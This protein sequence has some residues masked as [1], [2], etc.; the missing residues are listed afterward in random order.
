ML[1]IY[2]RLHVIVMLRTENNS[3]CGSASGDLGQS[4]LLCVCFRF[5]LRAHDI[6]V[7]PF[8][9]PTTASVPHRPINAYILQSS[10]IKI[11]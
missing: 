10:V 8:H 3:R 9:V 11:T 2:I 1:S 5:S 6:Y 7:R 4:L